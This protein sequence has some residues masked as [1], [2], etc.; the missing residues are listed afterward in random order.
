M[1]IDL[2]SLQDHS[3]ADIAKAAKHAMVAAALGGGSLSIGGV[4]VGRIS[5]EEAKSL[6]LLA[7]EML[8]TEAGGEL[9]GMFALAQFGETQ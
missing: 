5:V 4:N 3:W 8:A 2:S 7:Q 9:G 1:A 6:Y